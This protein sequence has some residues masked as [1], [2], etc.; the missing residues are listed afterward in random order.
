MS[1]AFTE[2]EVDHLLE[3]I[4]YG[5]VAAPVWFLGMEEAGGG[6]DNLRVRLKFNSIEDLR[7]ADLKL[8]ITRFHEEKKPK[9]QRTWRAMSYIMLSRDQLKP[10][11]DSIRKYQS[12]QL[13]RSGGS[14]LL[15]EL[16]PIPKPRMNSWD[17]GCLLPQFQSPDD[18]ERIVKPRRVEMIRELIKQHPPRIL[19]AYGKKYWDDFRRLFPDTTFAVEN[20]FEWVVSGK[21]LVILSDHFTAPSMNG[22]LKNLVDLICSRQ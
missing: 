5:S 4:G 14:T 17:Y 10:T 7:D 13:G 3:F 19:V 15:L 11:R 20:K 1:T 12:Q 6:E 9:I 21:T 2:A 22:Q 18:Y 16:M 8:G